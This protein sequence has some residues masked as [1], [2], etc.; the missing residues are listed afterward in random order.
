[1]KAFHRSSLIILESFLALTAIG[2]AIG[3]LTGTGAPPREILTHSPFAD[4]TVPG[5]A[6]L[7]IVGGPAL[8]AVILLARKDPRDLLVCGLTAF[9]IIIFESVE[10]LSIGSPA[11]IARNLQVLYIMVGALIG[12]IALSAR[13]REAA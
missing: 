8:V 1:M 12:G 9:S 13:R 6:L 4:Y 2:G 7:L 5:L 3:L 11:G 10:I